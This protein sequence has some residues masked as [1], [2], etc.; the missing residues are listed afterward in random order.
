MSKYDWDDIENQID[1]IGREGLSYR[2]L[3]KL[4]GIPVMTLHDHIDL[5]SKPKLE[6]NAN[7]DF[8]QTPETMAARAG[9]DLTKYIVKSFDC[10]IREVK[11]KLN[12]ISKIKLEPIETKPRELTLAPVFISIPAPDKTEC[13]NKFDGHTTLL[14]PDIHFGF[15]EYGPYHDEDLLDQVIEFTSWLHPDEIVLLGDLLDLAEFTDKFVL[16][17]QAVNTTQKSI[18]ECAKFLANLRSLCSEVPITLLEGN[19]EY[20]MSSQL[21]KYLMALA[22]LKPANSD[23]P[24]SIATFLNLTDLGV[25]YV[26][27]WPENYVQINDVRILHGDLLGSNP[28]QTVSKMLDKYEQSTVFGHT[29]HREYAETTV[30][31]DKILD[32]KTIFS[33]SPG[34]LCRVDGSVPGSSASNGWRQGI[35]ILRTQ[36]EGSSFIQDIGYDGKVKRFLV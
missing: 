9:I 11:N 28:G 27:G 31:S 15:G 36:L 34:C 16:N 20:R 5:H 18:N 30:W 32:Y 21:R 12:W 17:P 8:P 2:K 35:G 3:S 14:L 6:L 10:Q 19:H 23:V 7:N 33:Y 13:K 26:D 22:G 25:K 4:L 24:I 29:H 1:N